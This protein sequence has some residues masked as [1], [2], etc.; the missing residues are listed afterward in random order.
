MHI[1]LLLGVISS[2]YSTTF[3]LSTQTDEVTTFNLSTQTD[4]MTTFNLSTQ[5]DEVTTFNLSTQTDEV[6]TF[7]LSTQTDEVTTFNLSTQTDEMT[8]FK[9]PHSVLNDLNIYNN[10][11]VVKSDTSKVYDYCKYVI[12]LAAYMISS[13]Y[14]CL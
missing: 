7:N 13:V 2:L 6:T 14:I 4:E 9:Q 11:Q 12:I 1:S 10:S 3:N 8:T 5:T